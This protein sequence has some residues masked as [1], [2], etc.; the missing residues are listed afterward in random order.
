MAD[1][2]SKSYTLR[3]FVILGALVIFGAT[4]VCRLFLLQVVR[5]DYYLAL[6]RGQHKIIE[7]IKPQRGNI[8]LQAK[9]REQ[10]D[11]F[12]V[13]TN[14]EWRGV[15]LVPQDIKE[16]ERVVK[17]LSSILGVGS[18][19][20]EAKVAKLN[21]PYEPINERVEDGK[22]EAIK[23]LNLEGVGISK[24]HLRFYPYG[25]LASHLVGFM[26][27]VEDERT[28]RYGLEEYYNKELQGSP[29][30]VEV[31][32]GLGARALEFMKK[33][34]KPV[35]DGASIVVTI[36]YNIQSKTEEVLREYVDK[37][38]A[39]SGSIIVADPKTGA[40]LSMASLPDFDI[41]YYNEVEDINTY[42]N[43]VTQKLFEPGSIFKPI[44][45]AGALNEGVIGPE[46]TYY[47]EGE[48]KIGGYTIQNSDLKKHDWQTMTEVLEKSLNTGAMYVEGLLGKDRFKGYVE[49]FG[50]N[51]KTGIDL[52]GE[53]RGDISN[54]E[55]GRDINF[56]TASFGQGIAV[57]PI[58]LITAFSAIA[59]GGNMVKPHIMDSIVYP[60]GSTSTYEQDIIKDVISSATASR[61]TAMLVSVVK[62]GHS[63]K[64]GVEGYL[65][66][67]KT[68][69]AQVPKEDG[70]GYS[71]KT[72][73]SFIGFT[74]AFNPRFIILIKLDNPKGIRFAADSTT[75]AFRKLAEYILA[76]YEIP[77]Q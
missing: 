21:D 64:A 70:Q 42:L 74:P 8:I 77:P 56:A 60:D 3:Y 37:W 48:V 59:N 25:S 40:I 71:E 14:K 12:I 13:A 51:K 47:D 57:T 55:S 45:M 9:E 44:T 65:V 11:S 75:P 52:P 15:Y 76:Y 23:K 1:K 33:F 58:E 54:L 5:G 63:K 27:F 67:G 73:H 36:D 31:E 17:E 43:P 10:G 41:N 6:A 49:K 53:L 29:G 39:E 18:E 26:G 50:F 28:G 32:R 61:L 38:G 4:I 22:I 20:L 2:Y 7:D 24:N 62:N 34:L 68:G 46:T 35:E 19:S 72:I 69:T 16:K 30:I 66:A